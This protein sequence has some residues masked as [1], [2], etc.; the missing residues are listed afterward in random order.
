MPSK[1]NF[2]L[3]LF[4]PHLAG[5]LR[6]LSLR[7]TGMQGVSP[8]TSTQLGSDGRVS[9]LTDL[10]NRSEACGKSSPFFRSFEAQGLP[11]DTYF[12]SCF[13]YSGDYATKKIG[14]MGRF[15]TATVDYP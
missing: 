14:K 2:Q 5:S 4:R 13:G 12:V 3:L 9:S 7:V 1:H 11:R 10:G 15:P 8:H 6:P